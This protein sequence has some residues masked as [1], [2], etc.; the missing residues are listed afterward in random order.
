[1]GLTYVCRINLTNNLK[2][3]KRASLL[4]PG[5]RCSVRCFNDDEINSNYVSTFIQ[6]IMCSSFLKL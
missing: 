2:A 3:G 5:V 1:M 4:M 6:R